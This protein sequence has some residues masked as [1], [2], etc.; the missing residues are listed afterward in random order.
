MLATVLLNFNSISIAGRNTLFSSI[1]P[2][3]PSYD[4]IKMENKYNADLSGITSTWEETSVLTET[5]I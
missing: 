1:H 4:V 3:L 5:D 2:T